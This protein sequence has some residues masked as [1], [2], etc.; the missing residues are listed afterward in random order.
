MG[1][2]DFLNNLKNAVETGNFNSEAAK[3]I[4]EIVKHVETEI[5]KKSVTELEEALDKRLEESGV[6]TISEEE[7]GEI[8]TV[9]MT[10][11]EEKMKAFKEQDKVNSEIALL[12]NFNNDLMNRLTELGNTIALLG[13]KYEGQTKKW[14]DLFNLMDS[15]TEKYNLEKNVNE[16]E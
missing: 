9:D 13:K 6:K 14:T 16:A 3:K 11:Y 2:E 7:L 10:E 1:Q 5:E 4:N 12:H 8:K 15:L